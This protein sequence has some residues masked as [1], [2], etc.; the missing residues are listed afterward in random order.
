[1]QAFSDVTDGFPFDKVQYAIKS[2]VS[3]AT[4]ARSR[5]LTQEGSVKKTIELQFNVQVH[6]HVHTCIH[7]IVHV[8]VF[9]VI[10]M[11]LQGLA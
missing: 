4:L 9:V 10:C 5:L 2:S 11:L 1:M 8:C 6:V 3:M 7:D